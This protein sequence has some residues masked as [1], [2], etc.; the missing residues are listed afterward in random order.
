MGAVPSKYDINRTEEEYPRLSRFEWDFSTCPAWELEECW[1]YEFKRE[2]PVVRLI[3][4][5]WRKNCDP[6]TFGL[7]LHLAQMMLIPPERKHL[8]AFCPEWPSCPYLSIPPAERK[9][10]FSQSFR[11]ETESLAAELEPRP[12][13]PGALSLQEVNC[14]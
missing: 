5:D 1:Y 3:I 14:I 6:P 13:P 11:N 10:R 2:S 8:Y 7:F 4:V 9:R 12:A